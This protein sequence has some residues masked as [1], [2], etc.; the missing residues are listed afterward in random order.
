[1]GL[2]G[3]QLEARLVTHGCPDICVPKFATL[4]IR[5]GSIHRSIRCR[6]GRFLIE[7]SRLNDKLV[8]P[9]AGWMPRIAKTNQPPF[10]PLHPRRLLGQHVVPYRF[11]L[12]NFEDAAGSPITLN[13]NDENPHR[14]ENEQGIEET[15]STLR[16]DHSVG[17]QYELFSDTAEVLCRT[18][19]LYRNP[20]DVK[21]SPF[22][23]DGKM[24]TRFLTKI[25]GVR[26]KSDV[27][28]VAFSG[29]DAIGLNFF[30]PSARYVN[31]VSQSTCEL[32]S[33]AKSLGLIRVGVFVNEPATVVS[34]IAEQVELDSV[35]LHGDET[36]QWLA[37]FAAVSPLPV[38][39]A[40]KLP[41]IGLTTPIIAARS[42]TWLDHGCRVLL[43]AD[44][45]AA[46]GGGGKT[47]DWTV[48]GQWSQSIEADRW[49]LAGGLNPENVAQAKRL[50]GSKSVDT[51]SGVE[52]IGGPKGQKSPDRIAAF[53]FAAGMSRS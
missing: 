16:V 33:L 45:G 10:D 41:T 18:H 48:V 23:R 44:A 32:S 20:S 27:Q 7:C 22:V 49:T 38:I 14:R 28:A 5:V 8:S 13:A 15:D 52:V 50:S 53:A 42:R 47:L 24:T 4:E 35:Q 46:H 51:A 37:D 31:P 40:V 43:D 21:N 1:M 26:L 12:V 39:K 9:Q 11:P 34:K 29:A 17:D 25:C 2:I 6:R 19:F 3:L 36:V 30:L